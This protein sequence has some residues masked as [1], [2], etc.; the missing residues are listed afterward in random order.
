MS[1]DVH[2]SPHTYTNHGCRCAS[3]TAAHNEYQ[4]EK[5]A[6]RYERTRLNGGVAPVWQHNYSTYA[7][8][9][10]RCDRCRASHAAKSREKYA[11]KRAAS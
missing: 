8:W 6:T 2:G 3:C 11:A 4:A 5:R 1:A 10:C 9:G 7:M